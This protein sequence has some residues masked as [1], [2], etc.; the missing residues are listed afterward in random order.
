MAHW[1]IALALGPNY[2]IDVDD[3]REKEAYNEIQQAKDLSASA[4]RPEQDYIAA[5]AK[6]YSNTPSPD[7]KKLA[8]DYSNAMRDLMSRKRS[9]MWRW[10]SLVDF[11]SIIPIRQPF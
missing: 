4:S 6:R 5:L 3:Q 2:N 11:P 8:A 9:S 10:I 1:G 7:L